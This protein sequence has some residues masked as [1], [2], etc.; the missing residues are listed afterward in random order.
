MSKHPDPIEMARRLESYDDFEGRLIRA[1]GATV[2]G[3]SL[4]KAL[5]FRSQEAFRKALQRGRLSIRTFSIEGRRGR[6]AATVDVAAWL[7]C[8]RSGS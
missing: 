7:W 8:Q 6:F 3:E 5:G 1:L 2:G 4:T